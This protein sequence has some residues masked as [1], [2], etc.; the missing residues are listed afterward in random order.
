MYLTVSHLLLVRFDLQPYIT[1][2]PQFFLPST[3]D[4]FWRGRKRK[5]GRKNVREEERNETWERRGS[6]IMKR[7]LEKETVN[8]EEREELLVNVSRVIKGSQV[9]VT[10]FPLPFFFLSQFLHFFLSLSYFSSLFFP[11]RIP[12]SRLFYSFVLSSAFFL[13][14]D[15]H[16]PFKPRSLTWHY[17]VLS[18]SL[19]LFI[20]LFLHFF[21]FFFSLS[22]Y[23]Y[24][25]PSFCHFLTF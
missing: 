10:M 13:L 9:L 23:L 12:F 25:S 16:F 15:H 1:R 14:Y 18:P 8:S 24:S 19:F 22:L 2:F 7:K 4:T 3:K 20:L 11:F 17:P 5:W 21:F 6:R